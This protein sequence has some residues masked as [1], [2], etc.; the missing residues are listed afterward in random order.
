[1]RVV[2]DDSVEW[3]SDR[4][5]TADWRPGEHVVPVLRVP[6]DY[7]VSSRPGTRFGPNAIVAAL[8]GL[9]LYCTDKRI[10]LT[11]VRFLDAG[12]VDV[13]HD[14]AHT[15]RAIADAV[16]RLPAGT[17]PVVLGGDHSI[18]DP[19][20]R[21]LLRRE[22]D[23]GFG[24]VVFDAHFD[25]RTPVPGKEHSGHWMKTIED[26]VDYHAVV[27]LGINA[28]IYSDA[29]MR[30]AE[31]RGVLVRTPYD[32]RGQGWQRTVKE[33]VAHASNPTGRVYISVDVDVMDQSVAPGTSVPNP[34]GLLPHEVADAVFEISRR[35]D[36]VGLDVVEV[37]PP[38]DRLDATAH[39]AAHIVLNHLAGV[40]AKR[41]SAVPSGSAS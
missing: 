25:S 27:Q 31:H 18:T 35:A 19:V 16:A 30:D 24:I 14:L 7:A 40:M 33:A 2:E 29:Y 13:V 21:G 36:V 26:V 15:Y 32:I 37:S 11:D 9:S 4:W 5:V 41:R 38:L 28:P 17:S 3:I 10:P 8:N 20:I 34:C 1:M 12:E 23:H 6:L 39:V 22:A